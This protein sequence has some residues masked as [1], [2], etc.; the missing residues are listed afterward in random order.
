M[1]LGEFFVADLIDQ[2]DAKCAHP[3]STHTDTRVHATIPN[4]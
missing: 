2:D 4:A 1:L 3:A